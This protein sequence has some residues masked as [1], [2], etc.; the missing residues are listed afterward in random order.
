M[1]KCIKKAL[2]YIKQDAPDDQ[3]HKLR[4]EFNDAINIREQRVQGM[5]YYKGS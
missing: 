4:K 1:A 5:D 2:R 3:L